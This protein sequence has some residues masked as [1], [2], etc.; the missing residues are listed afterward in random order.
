MKKNCLFTN[1]FMLA[2]CGL[3]FT[4][5]AQAQATRTW[6]SGFGDDANPCSRTA[7]CKTFAGAISRTAAGGEIDAID[8]AGYGTLTIT[9]SITV[10]GGG[11]LASVLATSGANGFVINAGPNDVISLRNL[12]INGIGTGANGIR[13]LAGKSLHVENVI[14]AHVTTDG[15][16]VNLTATGDVTVL[17]TV[18]RDCGATGV[19]LTGSAQVNATLV[20]VQTEKCAN[21]VSAG[22]NVR[23]AIA[24]STMSLNS[25]VGLFGVGPNTEVNVDRCTIAFN[26]VGVESGLAAAVI[27]LTGNSITDNG[28]GILRMAGQING[29]GTNIV[30]GN[31]SDG[32]GSITPQ[33]LH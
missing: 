1:T 29:F 4:S 13:F 33:A 10:D 23:A 14:I 31:A 27:K 17:N 3:A 24:E 7:P 12:S 19:S 20:N 32:T 8:P 30:F 28:T 9:K 5:A 18:I 21:G 25:Q 2:L 16:D 26:N 15:I 11:S 22:A 6:V